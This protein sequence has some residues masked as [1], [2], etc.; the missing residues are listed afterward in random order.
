[1][2]NPLRPTRRI[3]LGSRRKS[4]RRSW[5]AGRRAWTIP[6]GRRRGR[7]RRRQQRGLPRVRPVQL[8]QAA[9]GA[10]RVP[11]RRRHRHL[12]GR[13]IRGRRDSSSSRPGMAPRSASPLPRVLEMPARNLANAAG[14]TFARHA[15]DLIATRR[16]TGRTKVARVA[17]TAKASRRRSAKQRGWGKRLRSQSQRA[18]PSPRRWRHR[19]RSPS[20]LRRHHRLG[21]QGLRRRRRKAR[22]H[23]LRRRLLRG[24]VHQGRDRGAGVP[25]RLL[26]LSL[27]LV[28]QC[29]SRFSSSSSRGQHPSA[30]Q[31]RLLHRRRMSSERRIPGEAQTR[32]CCRTSSYTTA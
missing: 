12:V 24:R 16:A 17:R 2:G 4:G 26:A 3:R 23:Q 30:R 7:R 32:I 20:C 14:L 19:R 6:R 28:S 25:A 10:V 9:A 29:G 15:L 27:R 18:Y 11:A 8:R 5:A 21:G 31:C 13:P 22:C 1:M